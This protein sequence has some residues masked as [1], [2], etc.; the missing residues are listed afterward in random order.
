MK[1]EDW[2]KTPRFIGSSDKLVGGTIYAFDGIDVFVGE[3]SA[4]LIHMKTKEVTGGEADESFGS[5]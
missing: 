1:H 5:V 4:R 3:S 2:T